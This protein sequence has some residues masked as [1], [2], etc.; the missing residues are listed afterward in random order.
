[1]KF[2]A[3]NSANWYGLRA[4]ARDCV[5][6]R[7]R[8]DMTQNIRVKIRGCFLG[9]DAGERMIQARYLCR[10]IAEA[11]KYGGEL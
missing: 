3:Q 8:A 11:R 1:M 9:L 2:I 10:F 6:Y 7:G 4:I 5:K